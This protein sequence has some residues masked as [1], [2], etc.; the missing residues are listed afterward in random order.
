MELYNGKYC[1][2]Y[3]DLACIMSRDQIMRHAERVCRGGN[4]RAAL[5][6]VD[7]LPIRFKIEVMRRYPDLQAQAECKEFI[8]TIIPDTVAEAFYADYKIDGV[9]GLDY[10]K[11]REYSNNATILG[12]FRDLLMRASSAR[13]KFGKRVNKGEFWANKAK[14]LPRIADRYPHSLPENARR[15]QEKFNEFFAGGNANYEVLISRKFQNANAAKVATDEQEACIVKLMSDHRNFDNEQ[16]AMVYNAIAEKMGWQSITASA[17]KSWRKK[18]DLETAGGRLGAREFYNQRSMQVRRSAPTAPLYMWSLDGWDAELYYQ[19]TT[20]RGGK[21]VTTYSNRLT[22]V[23]V[24]DPFNKY[25][26]GYAIGEQECSALITAALRNAANHTAELFGQRYRANQ[27]QSDHYALK[28]MLPIYGTS[29]EKVVPARVGNAKAKPIERYFLSLNK[30]YCQFMPNWSGF[31]ITS[32]KDSQPNSDALNILRK[33]FPDEAG[34]RRQIEAIIA[35]ERMKKRD[36]FVAAWQGVPADRR[37]PMSDEQY[38]LAFGQRS[39][40]RNALEGSGLNV[41]LL[42]SK[43]SYDCFDVNFRKYSHIRWS[44]VYDPDNLDRVLA[45]NEDGSLRFMLEEKYVQP[46]ALVDRTEGDAA[47]LTRIQQFNSQ[48]L[49]PHVVNVIG[50]A[51]R[52]VELLF[53]HNPQLDNT[54]S[55]VLLCDSLGQHKDRR[56]E[57]RLAAPNIDDVDVQAEAPIT[58]Q[59]TSTFDLY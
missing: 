45:V 42:G 49:E 35:A 54:L 24:L 56:N 18:Y 14:L 52:K 3:D 37:L 27:I 39:D 28:T 20:T 8:D 55:R 41:R 10:D 44:V 7:S 46:M 12:A 36:K 32:D 17:I 34:C 2:S 47:E 15:L 51:S 43:R 5:Y 11:Q 53:T 57:N 31:G 30:N 40:H 9:R 38:L 4:G 6:A 48:E 22:V 33:Q 21:S 13:G 25:P 29:G 58:G 26:I 50:E 23:V 59:K 1:A 19:K 16:I